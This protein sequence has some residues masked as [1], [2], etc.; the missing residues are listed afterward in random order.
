[1]ETPREYINWVGI[2]VLSSALKRRCY[3]WY[4]GI[5]FY[6]NQYIILVG[7]P[8]IGKGES[9]NA[10]TKIANEVKAINYIKDWVTPQEIIEE[11]SAGFQHINLKPGQVITTNVVQDHTCCIM[12]PELAVFLQQYDNLH[13]LMCAWWDQ[14][15]FD[16]KTKNKGKH[17]I[18]DM[19]VSLLGGCV[20]DYVRSLSK[21][22]LAPITGGFTARTI[23]VYATEKFQLIDNSFGAP[24]GSKTKIHDDLV[25]DLR[26]ITT[27]TGELR[28]S[29]DAETLWQQVYQEHNKR[30]AIDSDA[31][32]NFKSRIS[33]HIIKTAVTISIS[34]S[35]NLVITRDHLDT[36]IRLIEGIR[37]K[38]DIVFRSIGESPLA[39]TMDK[40]IK[41]VDMKGIVLYK[42]LLKY[43]MRDATQDQLNG[44]LQVLVK[45]GMIVEKINVNSQVEYWST[46]FIK[47]Q[48]AGNP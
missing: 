20:P 19:S 6:P 35:D 5:K 41:L 33:S 22:R 11:L 27:L 23:F 2:S 9:I 29:K 21:D 14:N 39:V 12:A 16:Y 17:V 18:E 48:G 10:A 30:G 26:H 37:D 44:I 38:V 25:N 8:G 7:P 4:R 32:A 15:K 45:T 28:I 24:N 13:S 31:S 1:M 36:A 43:V 47:T 42:E 34:D 40:V 3:I 46:N